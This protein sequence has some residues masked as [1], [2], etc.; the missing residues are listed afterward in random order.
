LSDYITEEESN[1]PDYV[2][3]FAVCTGYGVDELAKIY[4]QNHDD[5]KSIMLK[6]LADRL[7]EAC[8][9]WLHEKVRKEIC[10]YAEDENLNNEQLIKENYIGI[11]PAP[12][13]PACPDHSEKRTLFQLLNVTENIGLKLT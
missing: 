1:K 2:G 8:A 3:A 5:Y 4:E 13:Y 6:A 11:R 10:A 12:G 9:E 7:A